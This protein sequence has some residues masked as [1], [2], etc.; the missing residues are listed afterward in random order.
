MI[1]KTFQ[2]KG[3]K[4]IRLDK[5]L[6]SLMESESRNIIK[7]HI[8]NSSIVVN[9]KSIKPS[10][11][12]Q[13]GDVIDVLI[14]FEKKIVNGVLVPENIDIDVLYEDQDMIA[15]NKPSG[16]V[17]H[18]GI[19]NEKGTLANALVY[20]FD[21]LSDVNG[22]NRKGIVHRLDADTSGVVLV[23]KTNESHMWLAN[24]FK[25]RTIQKVYYAITWGKW[26]MKE[27]VIEGKMI[28]KKSDPTSYTIENGEDGKYS[29]SFFKVLKQFSNFSCLEFRPYTGRT[30]QIRVHASS[31]GNPIFGDDKYGGGIKKSNEFNPKFGKNASNLIST[32]N[33]H[34]LH[35]SSIEFELMN[36]NGKRIKIDS[37]IPEE[38]TSLEKSLAKYEN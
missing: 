29:K 21:N 27:G 25:T 22:E 28:R 13:D 19:Q 2:V 12:L 7:R 26:S 17:I 3:S 16:L 30:H 20:H 24:Q 6:S 9:G 36:S 35:A 1:K 33:R 15:L 8:K 38:L 5:Y 37:P 34:A 31:V 32:I 11:L 14:N 18:P 23:A 4:E 10:Y